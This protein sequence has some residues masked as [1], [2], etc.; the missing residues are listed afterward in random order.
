LSGT[1]GCGENRFVG[2]VDNYL[3]FI[4]EAGCTIKVKPVD[5]IAA[6][7]RMDWTLD[8]FYDQGGQTAFA[9]RVAGVLGIHA[10]R[11]KVVNVYKGSVVVDFNVEAEPEPEEPETPEETTDESTD[12]PSDDSSDSGGD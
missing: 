2:G 9:D 1:A 8:Q 6:N 10:S 11:V 4:L 7:V 3:E 12:P 5:S